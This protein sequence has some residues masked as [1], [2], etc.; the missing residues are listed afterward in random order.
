MIEE[1][2]Q[3]TELLVTLPELALWGLVGFGIFKLIVYLST[4][5]AAIYAL[6]IIAASTLKIYTTEKK[7][8]Y[9]YGTD[10]FID[11][12]LKKRFENLIK[13]SMFSTGVF[14]HESDLELLE[15]AVESILDKRK[16]AD[17]Q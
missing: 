14:M 12:N 5:G 11:R 3:L 2:K 15:E 1:L 9:Q 16:K 17:A 10:Y 8:T 13:R 4:T 6:K 7:V